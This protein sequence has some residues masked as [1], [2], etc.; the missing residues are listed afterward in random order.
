LVK[1]EEGLESSEWSSL[2]G[3]L[4]EPG[5]RPAWLETAMGFGVGGYKDTASGRRKFLEILEERVDWAAP[6]KAGR[7]YSAGEGKTKLAVYSTLK[8]GWF[9]G[10]QEFKERLVQIMEKRASGRRRRSGVEAA[11]V[12]D[13]GEWRARRI[14]EA[15]LVVFGVTMPDLRKAAK[16][17]WRKGL[18]AE[19]MQRQ[20]TMKL[21][22]ISQELENGRP[23]KLLPT[24]SKDP[25]GSAEAARVGE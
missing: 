8:R 15:G 5:R 10:S 23:V 9:F 2:R 24:D 25:G 14:A 20:T 3:Y 21:D 4:Q 13:H 16:S 22:W 11:A 1:R 12:E 18:M 17:D 6:G 19:M 7:E